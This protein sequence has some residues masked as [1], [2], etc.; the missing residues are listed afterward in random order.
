MD[1]WRTPGD[2]V[3]E[4]DV[5][6][7]ST[8]LDFTSLDLDAEGNNERVAPEDTDDWASEDYTS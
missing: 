1:R 8:A 2:V 7:D 5:I 3:N 4:D 6:A